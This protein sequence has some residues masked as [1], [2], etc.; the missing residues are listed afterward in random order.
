MKILCLGSMNIDHVYQVDHF[1]QGGETIASLAME[2]HCGGKGLNQAVALKQAGADVYMAGMT[3]ADGS[4]LLA[5]LNEKAV[6]TTCVRILA[7]SPSG[8]AI[9]QVNPSGQN[10]IIIHGGAN[11]CIDEAYIDMVYGRFNSGD[12]VLLQNEISCLPYAIRRA[13]QLGL[14]VALNPSPITPQLAALEELQDVSWFILNEIEGNLLTGEHSAEAICQAM[15]SAY[16]MAQTMLTLGKSGCIF[17]DGERFYHHGIYD[18]PVVDTTAAGDT[19]TGYFLAGISEGLPLPRVL[20]LAS[21]A[22]SLAVSKAGAAQSI[23][24]RQTVETVK[25]TQVQ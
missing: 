20:E 16:P 24:N 2:D 4:S 19:F 1:A 23:P 8:H 14:R 7:H 17:F 18:V 9:I 12:I 3:G 25:L 6:D 10:C 15:K 22:S 13:R 21:T 11:A 5:L